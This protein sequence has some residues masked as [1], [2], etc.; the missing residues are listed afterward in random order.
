V[1]R[2]TVYASVGVGL[3]SVGEDMPEMPNGFVIAFR[4]PAGLP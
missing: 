2:N 3:T 1:A 4:P